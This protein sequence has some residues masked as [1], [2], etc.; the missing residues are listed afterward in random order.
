MNSIEECVIAVVVLDRFHCAVHTVYD[1]CNGDI[2]YKP[3]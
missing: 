2:L 3:Y 1:E